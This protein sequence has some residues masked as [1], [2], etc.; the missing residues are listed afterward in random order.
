MWKLYFLSFLF[1]FFSLLL[2]QIYFIFSFFLF[3]PFSVPFSH[4]HLSP[5][6]FPASHHPACLFRNSVR[7]TFRRCQ[8]ATGA[9]SN[10][11]RRWL[12]NPVSRPSFAYWDDE[13][14]YCCWGR[15]GG[16]MRGGF[17]HFR[18]NKKEEE[19]EEEEEETKWRLQVA[20]RIFGIPPPLM[21]ETGP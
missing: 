21:T 12:V 10:Q 18:R 15:E 13:P 9:R 5:T 6:H 7:Q 8:S 4:D 2:A 3:L 17:P 14:G 1:S 16:G 20:G 11:R 19:E